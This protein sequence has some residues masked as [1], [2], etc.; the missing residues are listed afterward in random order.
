MAPGGDGEDEGQTA[1]RRTDLK[2]RRE[3]LGHPDFWREI[4]TLM[5]DGVAVADRDGVLIDVNPAFTKLMG[6]EREELLGLAPPFPFWPREGRAAIE[7][8]FA[9]TMTGA[10]IDSELEFCRKDGSRFSALVHPV[11]ITNPSGN[12]DGAFATFKD[13]SA[14]KQLERTLRSSEERWR[15]IAEN[16]YDFVVIIDADYK[17]T[18]VNHT[19]PGIR[20]EDLIGRATPFDFVEPAFH[21]SMRAAF[22]R[23]FQ[24]GAATTYDLHV[25]I[26]GRW[27][28]NIVGPIKTN[29]AV[30]ALSILTRDV[31]DA[32]VAEHALRQ[33]E[34]RLRLA[35]DGGEV[36]IFD[37][38]LGRGDPFY[39]PRL[40]EILGYH[41]DVNVPEDARIDTFIARL[42]PA[43]REE[44]VRILRAAMAGGEPF[45]HEYRVAS[46]DSYRWVHSRGRSL[47]DP[48]GVMH[49]SGCVTDISA[50]KE[51][52]AQRTQLEAQLRQLQK[53]DTLGRLAAGLAHD[54]N[55]LLVPILG[56]AELILGDVG[57]ASRFRSGLEDIIQA[58]TRARELAGRILVFGRQSD[59]LPRPTRAPVIVREAVRFLRAS[60]PKEVEIVEQIDD[61]CPEIM[62]IPGQIHQAV[63][64][65]CTNAYQALKGR[66]GRILVA[67]EPV[68][69]D[70]PFAVHHRMAEGPALRIVV[71]DDGPGMPTEILERAFE[72]FFTTKPAG[73]GSGLGL[74]LVHGIVT[75]HQGAIVTRS[76]PA[77]GARFELYFPLQG[78][79]VGSYA[80]KESDSA[81]P[82][83]SIKRRILCVDDDA[84][85]LRVI[86]Q[87]FARAGHLVT[88]VRS[89]GQALERVRE[90]PLDYDVV[91]TDQTMPDLTG[92]QL[93]AKLYDLRRDLPVILLS[94]YA[95]A[96]LAEAAAP[97]VRLYLQKPLTAN[98]LLRAV[99]R[100]TS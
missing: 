63:S 71:E 88:S 55:N 21:A 16:P 76:A 56:N 61:A 60:V 27:F 9:R 91:V 31:T 50:R 41:L 28:S 98:A 64:N 81:P 70:A 42:H 18:Y 94:G 17:Y 44:T 69:I 79:A 77:E 43:D 48:G 19:A 6:F 58:S 75:Q 62:G 85:V 14:Q 3:R 54:F 59:E 5:A 66:G 10:P 36:G 84:T 25:E 92:L 96:S 33:S 72:P 29:G 38:E 22:E 53:M 46:Q 99:E 4:V 97:N 90:T 73:E 82:I 51:A 93:A 78:P 11:R 2:A 52:E 100:G 7:R 86:S 74:S 23:A 12:I 30:T 20:S 35:M 39:S 15:S 65:L 37:I 40:L 24:T 80:S 95:E 26:L 47:P 83:S 57:P 68:T 89:A 32:K 87:V 13:I 8:A 45:D 67:I 1:P 49:F 34:H